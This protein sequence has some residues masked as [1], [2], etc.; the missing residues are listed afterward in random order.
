MTTASH[1]GWT[2]FIADG[3]SAGN[4]ACGITSVAMA[5]AGRPDLSLAL[6]VAGGL[7]D[8]MDGAAARRFGGTRFGVLADDVADGVSY[9][10]APAVAVGAV[11]GGPAGIAL[12]LTFATLTVTRLVFF[13]LDK[14]NGDPAWFK[15]MPSPVGGLIALTAA[16]LFAGQPA[17]LGLLVGLAGALMVS[18]GLP[19]LHFGRAMSQSRA[20]KR[21]IALMGL[22]TAV[23]ALVGGAHAAAALMLA[24]ALAYAVAPVQKALRTARAA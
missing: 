18:F 13:T 6:I 4:L 22:A 12:G 11:V 21:A 3:L 5:A 9:G 19:Y 8:G 20:W 14:G 16:I 23:A 24:G 17:L 2:R 15:G 7:L 10:L 1:P